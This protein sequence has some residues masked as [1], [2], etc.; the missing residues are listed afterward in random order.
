MKFSNLVKRISGEGA[1]AWRTH[2][3]AA[4]ARERGEDVII[5]SIGDPDINAPEAVIE[6]AV[7]RLRSGDTHYTPARGRKALREAIAKAHTQRTGQAV[8]AENV[9]CLSG[10]QNALFVASLCLA[11][12]G[13]EV[14]TFDPLYPTYTATIDVSGAR[15]VR[16]PTGPGLRP[17]LG[18]LESLITPRTRAI[19][20]ATP[21]NPSGVILSEPELEAIGALARQHDLW[22]VSDEVYAGLAPGGKIPSLAATLSDRV[23]TLGSLSKSHSMPGFRAGWLVGPPELATHAESLSMCMLFGLPGFIQEAAVT[24][25]SIAP[26]TERSL[27]EF[28]DIRRERFMAGL[29][30]VPNIRAFAPQAGMF[31][32]VDVSGTG[33]SGYEFMRALYEKRQVSVLDGAAFGRQ[34]AHYVRICFATEEATIDAACQRIRQFCEIDLPQLGR[35][36]QAS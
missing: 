32:L 26:E 7:D 21:N 33:L 27:R 29:E 4:S 24:A 11:G 17:D 13:D 20:W 34:T 16:A 23:V 9:V 14:I 28:C 10:T 25:L 2:Y 5:L 15:L 3:E 6:C 31:L 22:I 1:D 12:P 36:R 8:H 30:G 35:Q 18:A 19:F